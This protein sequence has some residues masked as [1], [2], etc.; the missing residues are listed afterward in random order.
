LNGLNRKVSRERYL[1]EELSVLCGD[2]VDL[3][4]AVGGVGVGKVLVLRAQTLEVPL[5]DRR[6][7][8]GH[9]L[10]AA[11]VQQR[12]EDVLLVGLHHN[13]AHHDSGYGEAL[14]V[15]VEEE[16]GT[17]KGGGRVEDKRLTTGE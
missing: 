1:G 7:V 11:L 8:L 6:R 2:L 12:H 4:G 13:G 14:Q 10:D 5:Y 17:W 9:G 16:H 15:F 3:V